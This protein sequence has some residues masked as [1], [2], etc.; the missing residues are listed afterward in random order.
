MKNLKKSLVEL[1][2][3]ELE[4]LHDE[5]W[6]FGST[7]IKYSSALETLA[8]MLEQMTLDQKEWDLI[9]NELLHWQNMFENCPIPIDRLNLKVR[10]RTKTDK[11]SS[12]LVFE[13]LQALSYNDWTLIITEREHQYALTMV[14]E[15]I[16]NLKIERKK[17]NWVISEL[18]KL[19]FR[20]HQLRITEL[21]MF[22]KTTK[23]NSGV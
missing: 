11:S 20:E 2:C 23:R 1:I 21:V 16:K 4:K 10:E 12:E 9:T 13:Q 5:D 7:L 17:L 15:I 6:G 8:E 18:P 22:L 19:D 3:E 14:L